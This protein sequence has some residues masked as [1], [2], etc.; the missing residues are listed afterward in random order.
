[1]IS[2]RALCWIILAIGIMGFITGYWEG[3]NGETKTVTVHDIQT[4]IRTVDHIVTVTKTVHA[5][6]TTTETTKTEDKQTDK[7]ITDESNNSTTTPAG[8]NYSLGV[9]YHVGST[10]V[11]D[12]A[13]NPY[14]GIEVTAGR[15]IL[16]DIWLDLGIQPINR[17]VSLGIRIDL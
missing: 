17:D 16:G 14:R 5:D 6:G 12:I 4:V 11:A 15:R 8:S 7:D 9:R 10:D 1:M 2:I 3:G 13:A